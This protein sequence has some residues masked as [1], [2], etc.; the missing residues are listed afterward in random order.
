MENRLAKTPIISALVLGCT[1]LVQASDAMAISWVDWTSADTSSATGTVAGI[2][3]NF[4]G[5]I[6]P[7]AQTN[8]GTDFWT[9]FPGT[10]TAPPTVTTTPPASDIIRLTGGPG[11]GTQ[12]ITFSSP[13]VDPVMGIVSLGD[14]ELPVTY[15][16]D[17]EFDILSNGLGFFGSGPLAELPGNILEGE[18]G[19][20]LIQFSGTFSSISWTMPTAETWQGFTIGIID[21]EDPPELPEP[22]SI[23]SLLALGTL[24]TGLVLKRKLK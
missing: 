21:V 13:V 4:S 24:G 12:T 8:G 23:L 19:H 7:P 18:E 2:D 15:E 17:S 14:E 5:N 11:T 10:Y 3:V 22:S 9:I 6:S 20:G 16:F 1:I